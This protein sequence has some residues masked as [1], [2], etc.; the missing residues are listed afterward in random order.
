[1]K[2]SAPPQPLFHFLNGLYTFEEASDA[3]QT[4][5]GQLAVLS[6]PE[7]TARAESEVTS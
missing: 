6:H 4:Y 5:G 7:A 3:C 1:M 2:I